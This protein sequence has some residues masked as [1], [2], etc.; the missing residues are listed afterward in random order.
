[1]V[2][3]LVNNSFACSHSSTPILSDCEIVNMEARTLSDTLHHATSCLSPLP[4]HLYSPVNQA[5]IVTD[6]TIGFETSHKA[7]NAYQTDI[8]SVAGRG[9]E[10]VGGGG[11]D[12]EFEN[13]SAI[14]GQYNKSP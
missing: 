7:C 6:R 3:A 1:M 5:I 13:L 4:I 10:T 11:A 2:S 8:R 14:Y 9:R 12:K